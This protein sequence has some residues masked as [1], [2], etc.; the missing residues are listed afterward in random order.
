MELRTVTEIGQEIKKIRISKGMSAE[1]VAEKAGTNADEIRQFEDFGKDIDAELFAYICVALEIKR[2]N[3][4]FY[5]NE[6]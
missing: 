1:Y 2:P 6:L 4:L 3:D 5:K